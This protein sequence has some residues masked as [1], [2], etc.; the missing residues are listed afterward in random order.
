MMW[1]TGVLKLKVNFSLHVLF[2][3]ER[4]RLQFLRA[5]KQ[6]IDEATAR[7]WLGVSDKTA[8][9]RIGVTPY[10]AAKPSQV[11]NLQSE[12]EQ[13]ASQRR[14]ADKRARAPDVGGSMDAGTSVACFKLR[15]II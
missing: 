5:Q 4:Q 8:V 2:N 1:E 6:G 15:L 11:K 7:N 13:D 3:V 10:T 9:P 12:E 14:L